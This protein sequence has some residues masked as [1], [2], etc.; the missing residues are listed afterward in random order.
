MQHDSK[1][2]RDIIDGTGTPAEK[3]A[4]NHP[5]YVEK[6]LTGKEAEENLARHLAR[7]KPDA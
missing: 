6:S 1:N 4:I 3:A 7:K 2:W 5:P